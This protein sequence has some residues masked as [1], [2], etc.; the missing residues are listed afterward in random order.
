MKTVCPPEP[1]SD[2]VLTNSFGGGLQSFF[3]RS[4][5][6]VP[7]NVGNNRITNPSN[8]PTFNIVHGTPTDAQNYTTPDGQNFQVPPNADF[9]AV[10]NSGYENGL[11][12]AGDTVGHYGTADYQ[13]NEG[14]GKQGL[15]Y[16]YQAYTDASNYAVGV[17][18]GA[19]GYSS[20]E[21]SN[22]AT[23]FAGGMSDQISSRAPTMWQ[24][25]WNAAQNMGYTT[26]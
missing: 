8:D 12:G 15:D 25:G 4:P 23:A 9:Q 2:P 11:L 16:F 20:E 10:F 13:R 3:N 26:K 6:G 22:I 17:Y 19:A 21:T 1:R 5:I 14:G 18:L 24:S 7:S